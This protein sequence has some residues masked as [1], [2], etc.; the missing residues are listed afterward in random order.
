MVLGGD[1]H[2]ARLSLTP[3]TFVSLPRE[4]SVPQ[5]DEAVAMPEAIRTLELRSLPALP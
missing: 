4:P 2:R 5:R 3:L 1:G